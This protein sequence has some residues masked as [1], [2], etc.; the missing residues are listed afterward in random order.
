MHTES[1]PVIGLAMQGVR[2]ET[3]PIGASGR[4]AEAA[5]GGGWV[6][7]LAW[8]L[9]LLSGA[10]ACSVF[11]SGRMETPGLAKHSLRFPAEIR[12]EEVMHRA[13]PAPHARAHHFIVEILRQWG[14]F[15]PELGVARRR[16]VM[17]GIQ[18]AG[19]ALERQTFRQA[20]GCPADRALHGARFGAAQVLAVLAIPLIDEFPVDVLAIGQDDGPDILR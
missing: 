12:H 19:V 15:L 1:W 17:H 7:G 14:A 16:Q 4:I 10:G 11:G 2:Q 9:E 8:E 5:R 3:A 13:L 20:A 18:N 6:W